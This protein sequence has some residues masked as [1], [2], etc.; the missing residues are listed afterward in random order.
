MPINLVRQNVPFSI[1]TLRFKSAELESGF[2][3]WILRMRSI[4]MRLAMLLVGI[5]YVMLGLLDP[6]VCDEP[7]S[8]TARILHIGVMFPLLMLGIVIGSIERTQ[9][10]F[11]PAAFLMTLAAASGNLY[12]V[13]KMGLGCVYIPELF[14]II[15]WTFIVAGFRLWTAVALG[16]GIA[17]M[18]AV[19]ALST[20]QSS[21]AQLYSY[22]FWLFVALTLGF[23]GGHLLEYFSKANFYNTRQLQHAAQHDTLTELPNRSLLAERTGNAIRQAQ[24]RGEKLALVYIDLDNFKQLN[25]RWGHGTGD[26]YLR[27]VARRLKRC[28]RESDTVAR[29][30]G[31][32]FVVLLSNIRDAESALQIAHLLRDELM[33]PYRFEASVVIESGASIG[34]AIFPDHGSDEAELSARADT[35]MYLSKSSGRNRVTLYGT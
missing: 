7:L 28:V 19:T 24:R 5:L 11:I 12:L 9:R 14:F 8:S 22:L 35:A 4:Q 16:G 3:E 17:V 29:I 30:G 1:F 18:A 13:S 21:S 2:S 10:L 23:L 32:E 31:D 25:D 20:A 34:L 33:K 6:L 26:G 27:E 15:L